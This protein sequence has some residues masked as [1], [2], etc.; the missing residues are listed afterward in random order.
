M[1]R[2]LG[3]RGAANGGGVRRA[4][5][6]FGLRLRRRGEREGTAAGF[7]KRGEG[8]VEEGAC[9]LVRMWLLWLLCGRF[10]SR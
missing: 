6:A 3:W 9:G 1:R 2:G 4:A 5:A 8:C 10:R 7:I